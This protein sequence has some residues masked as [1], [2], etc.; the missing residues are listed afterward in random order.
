LILSYFSISPSLDF[1]YDHRSQDRP[2]S[3]AKREASTQKDVPPMAMAPT[4][5]KVV[6]SQVSGKYEIDGRE[7]RAELE[8]EMGSHEVMGDSRFLDSRYELAGN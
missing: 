6:N 1:Q 7:V 3:L 5:L 4:E 8:G 2:S